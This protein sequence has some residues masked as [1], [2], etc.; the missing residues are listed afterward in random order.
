MKPFRSFTNMPIHANYLP[1]QVY[2]L[3][4]CYRLAL[5]LGDL[6]EMTRILCN[7][8]YIYSGGISALDCG[9]RYVQEL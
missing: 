5:P 6:L 1:Q 9:E 3:L 2:S 8:R 7:L 4:V